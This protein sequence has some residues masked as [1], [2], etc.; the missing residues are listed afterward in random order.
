MTTWKENRERADLTMKGKATP[1][2]P[3]P[4]YKAESVLADDSRDSDPTEQTMTYPTNSK[5][6]SFLLL[7]PLI[8][9]NKCWV[10]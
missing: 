9:E 1:A 4:A 6:E 3:L 10:V 8:N 2:T 7:E 5:C